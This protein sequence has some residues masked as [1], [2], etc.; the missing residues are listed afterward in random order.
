MRHTYSGTGEVS[1]G[2]TVFAVAKDCCYGIDTITGEPLWRRV[3]GMD[4][5]FFPIP[6]ETSVSGVLLFD[7]NHNELTLLERRSGQLVWRQP[8]SP[9][10]R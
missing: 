10:S 8:S 4:S 3:I 7:T 9:I 1:V 6:V 2:R 5:P